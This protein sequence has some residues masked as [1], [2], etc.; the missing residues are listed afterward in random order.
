MS[1]A[2][3]VLGVAIVAILLVLWRGGSTK[4]KSPSIAASHSG[5]EFSARERD[6]NSE[7]EVRWEKAVYAKLT[8]RGMKPDTSCTCFFQTCSDQADSLSGEYLDGGIG[9]YRE[10][11][12]LKIVLGEDN[13]LDTEGKLNLWNVNDRSFSELNKIILR[14]RT[15]PTIVQPEPRYDHNGNKYWV[16]YERWFQTRIYEMRKRQEWDTEKSL[17]CE[18][19]IFAQ[20]RKIFDWLC[21]HTG[22]DCNADTQ[23]QPL[24]GYAD[25]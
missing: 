21:R 24:E 19:K 23:E 15:T 1:E 3:F 8:E 14:R 7:R 12:L 13:D 22:I 9:I 17:Y 6:R 16:P 5:I 18:F 4:A 25:R 2:L 11:K 20:D 10:A